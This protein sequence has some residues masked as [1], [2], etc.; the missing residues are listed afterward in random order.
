MKLIDWK[1]W[2]VFCRVVEGAGF[3]AGATLM[4]IRKSAA[5]AAVSR[6]E[7]ELG[8][9]LLERT[10]RRVRVTD[11]G[12]QFYDRIAPL[13]GELRE[14]GS[15]LSLAN[16]VVHGTLKI[17]TPYEVGAQYLS[18]SLARLMSMHPGLEVQVDVTWD[19]PD[20]VRDD[21]DVAFV[22][23]SDSLPDSSLAGKRVLRMERGFYAAPV[24]ADRLGPARTPDELVAWPAIGAPDEKNWEFVAAG[25]L[26]DR[27]LAVAPRLRTDNAEIRKRAAQ[28]GLGV[29]R[30][31]CPFVH[32]EV[33]N[34][35]LVRVLPDYASAPVKVYALMSTRKHRTANVHA[36]LGLL[37]AELGAAGAA[38]QGSPAAAHALAARRKA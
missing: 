11:A 26:E 29:A 18:S 33:R 13:F 25:T 23:T 15:D 4:G 1:D 8:V 31:T 27:R 7:A 19:Q 2:E 14:I 20:L 30:F 38:L 32:D 36:F 10:T 34:G 37:E 24:L 17:A 9:R 16:R 6:L 28:D 3:T 12:R 35:T 21:Y 5:S 22:M